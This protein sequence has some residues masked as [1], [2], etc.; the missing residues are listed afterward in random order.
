M[1]HGLRLPLRVVFYRED[2]AII[3]HCLEFDLL[4]D[5]PT[6][7]E[8]IERL[9][10]AIRI[11]VKEGVETGNLANLFT[12]APGEFFRMF[13]AG[14]SDEQLKEAVG[15]LKMHFEPLDVTEVDWREYHENDSAHQKL[16]LA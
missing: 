7:R 11:Q 5:G 10:E 16:A 2:E 4:G 9:A 3:A 15:V 8:A 12:P 14:D 13:A 1:N 6:H